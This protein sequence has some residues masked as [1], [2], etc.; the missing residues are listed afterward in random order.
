LPSLKNSYES[1]SPSIG[2][3]SFTPEETEGKLIYEVAEGQWN[4][5]KH[6]KQRQ[7]LL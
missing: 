5:P 6:K 4:I 2:V 3:F 7:F 1:E